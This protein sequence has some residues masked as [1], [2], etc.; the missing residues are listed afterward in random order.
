MRRCITIIALIACGCQD[1]GVARI[2]HD[3]VFTQGS[4]D[5]PID[6]LWVVDNSATMTEEQ[7]LLAAHFHAFADVLVGSGV[8]FR[9]GVT[10]TDVDEHAGALLGE[11]MVPETEDIADLFTEQAS[12]GITGSRDEQPL[13]AARLATSE[14]LVSEENAE[15]FNTDAGMQVIVLTD[16]DDHS[17]DDL[18]VYLDHLE[19]FKDGR[20]KISVIGGGLPEGCNSTTASAE[21]AEVLSYA[22]DATEGEFKSICEA[23]FEPVMKSLALATNGMTDRFLLSS[24]P[25]L[26]TMIV[27]VDGIAIHEREEDGWQ[28]DAADNA[29]VTYGLA[30]PRPGQEV[31]ITYQERLGA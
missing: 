20:F 13:E 9:M 3:D 4:P 27:A 2:S 18:S 19:D 31:R 16:E 1:Y 28:Y 14:P 21:A 26:D 8:D 12:V 22:V 25:A 11:V 23:D 7:D 15:L 6:I 17:R 30:I 10:T 29:V 5:Y 24:L